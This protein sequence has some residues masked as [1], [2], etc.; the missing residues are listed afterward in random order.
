MIIRVKVPQAGILEISTDEVRA[1]LS[2]QDLV[3]NE[4]IVDLNP[5]VVIEASEPT[6][7]TKQSGLTGLITIP[8]Q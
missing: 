4:A 7:N 5:V 3:K 1:L 2:L 6:I 8:G